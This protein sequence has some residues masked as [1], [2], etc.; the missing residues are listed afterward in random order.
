MVFLL[1][2]SPSATPNVQQEAHLSGGSIAD[3]KLKRSTCTDQGDAMLLSMIL[4]I[5]PQKTSVK[6]GWREVDMWTSVISGPH[7]RRS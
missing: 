6:I 2:D 1:L 7:L 3:A 5:Y 4:G